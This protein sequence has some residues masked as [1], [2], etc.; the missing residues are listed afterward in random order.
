MLPWFFDQCQGTYRTNP[1]HKTYTCQNKK[2]NNVEKLILSISGKV[3]I[4]IS[5]CVIK[6]YFH[7]INKIYEVDVGWSLYE[8]SETNH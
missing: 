7:E 1:S 3:K 8:M 6:Y 5:S 4:N 2:L